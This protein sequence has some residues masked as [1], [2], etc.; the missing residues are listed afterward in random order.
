MTAKTPADLTPRMRIMLAFARAI[1]M[2]EGHEPSPVEELCDIEPEHVPKADQVAKD[3]LRAVEAEITDAEIEKC[4]N[5]L[6]PDVE[7]Q[8][9][10]EHNDAILGQD[11]F[12][13]ALRK[14]VVALF[15]NLCA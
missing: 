7:Q 3:I 6:M 2:V 11:Q 8:K 13:S 14:F 10:D 1:E 5:Q 15:N 12:R 4:V 9:P